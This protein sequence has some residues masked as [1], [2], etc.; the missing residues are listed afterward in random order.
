MACFIGDASR[1]SKI[2]SET[3]LD[4]HFWIRLS[5]QSRLASGRIWGARLQ[6]RAETINALMH[7]WMH[8]PPQRCDAIS[9][10]VPDASPTRL[11]T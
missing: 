2:S 6:A 9:H 5:L 4:S 8:V 10:R 7:T 1:M 11:R 3:Y